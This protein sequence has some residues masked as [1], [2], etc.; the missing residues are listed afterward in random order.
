MVLSPGDRLGPYEIVSLIGAGGMGE[1]YRAT[2]TRLGRSVALKVVGDAF[3][4]DVTGRERFEREARTVAA[5]AHP[6]ICVLH[7]IGHYRSPESGYESDY[8]VMEH[9]EGETLA[10]RLAARSKGLPLIEALTVATQIASAL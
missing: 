5:L 6:H 2:D 7:D 3:R 9:L 8:L 4:D 10:A 1:V